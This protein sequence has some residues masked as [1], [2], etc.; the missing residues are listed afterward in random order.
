LRKLIICFYTFKDLFLNYST[1]SS[2]ETSETD[3]RKRP[4]KQ[5]LN[6]HTRIRALEDERRNL[7]LP[8]NLALEINEAITNRSNTASATGLRLVGRRKEQL[9]GGP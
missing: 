7:L 2:K 8:L 6:T 4:R 9:L 3:F 1:R 5:R